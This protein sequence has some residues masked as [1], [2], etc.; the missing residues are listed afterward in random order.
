MEIYGGHRPVLH[1]TFQFVIPP[2]HTRAG[3]GNEWQEER[4][5]DIIKPLLFNL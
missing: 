2:D 3:N 5:C 1:H 4:K